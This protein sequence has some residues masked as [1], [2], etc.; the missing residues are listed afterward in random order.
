VFLFVIDGFGV[1]HLL[2]ELLLLLL[3]EAFVFDA[4]A[5]EFGG[6]LDDL[7]RAEVLQQSTACGS[8]Q[9][10]VTY[11]NPG[12]PLFLRAAL[13]WTWLSP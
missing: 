6:V 8:H 9:L 3:A 4:L 1:L 7:E 2:V 11:G 10:M 12:E 5:Q 13:R